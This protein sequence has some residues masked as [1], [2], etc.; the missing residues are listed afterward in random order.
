MDQLR[1]DIV[2]D[3]AF[4]YS[5]KVFKASVVDLRRQGLGTTQHHPAITKADMIKLYSGDTFVFDI[6]T[7][8][9]LLNKVWFEILYYLCRRGQENL[10]TMTKETFQ[11]AIDSTGNR[12][13]FQKVDE[14]GKNHRDLNAGAVSQG[15]MYEQKGMKY[16]FLEKSSASYFCCVFKWFYANLNAGNPSC[17][18]HSF[19]KYLAKRNNDITALW[20]RP[21]ASFFP[22]SETWYCKAPL[23][24]NTLGKM[25]SEISQQG[26]LS[27]RYTN[28]SVRS[29]AITVLDEAGERYSIF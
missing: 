8:N 7:P 5:S 26:Q 19:L 1:G 9:G 27:Q 22:D 12:Y 11:L 15:R 17:P 6:H 20:Q 24:K 2:N 16:C 4:S 13:I 28:H 29:T 3:K 10:R 23:G 25:M 21:L 18:V 14:M